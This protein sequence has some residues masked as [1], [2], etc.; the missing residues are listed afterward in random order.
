[1]IHTNF[2]TR[3]PIRVVVYSEELVYPLGAAPEEA[4]YRQEYREFLLVLPYVITRRGQ[5]EVYQLKPIKS[6][7]IPSAV[8]IRLTNGILPHFRT[9]SF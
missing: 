6:T 8:E 4:D 7:S 3:T 5:L 2:Q 9:I 1:M